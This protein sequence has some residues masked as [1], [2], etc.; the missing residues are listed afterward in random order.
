[1][2]VKSHRAQELGGSIVQSLD[3]ENQM[4]KVIADSL[5]GGLQASRNGH[6]GVDCTTPKLQI[7]D[8][9]KV[10]AEVKGNTTLKKL[11]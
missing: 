3:N 5:E 11:M 1:M 2:F 6:P 4:G 9:E 10:A 7:G 8:S